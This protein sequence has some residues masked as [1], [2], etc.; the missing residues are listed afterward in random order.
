MYCLSVLLPFWT[1]LLQFLEVVIEAGGCTVLIRLD[2]L[3]SHDVVR[4]N[5]V[6]SID[7]EVNQLTHVRRVIVIVLG[8]EVAFDNHIGL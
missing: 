4:L 2:I 1:G 5:Q 3:N 7:V 8:F 6:L